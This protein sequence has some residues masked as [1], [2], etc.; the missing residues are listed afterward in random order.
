MAASTPTVKFYSL[1]PDTKPPVR[2]DKSV[3]GTIPT[4][5]YRYCDAVRS[6]SAFG[7]YVFPP[8][9]FS[10]MWDGTETMWRFDEEDDWKNLH[11]VQY[12]GF[13][14]YFN[15]HAPEEIEDCAPPIF[16]TAAEPGIV[17]IW[18]G[19]FAKTRKN[20]SLLV[21]PPANLARSAKY[22]SYEGIIETDRW[23]GPLFTNIRLTKT[24]VAVDITR[25]RPFMQVQPLHRSTYKDEVLNSFEHLDDISLLTKRNWQD[26]INTMV[27][28][29]VGSDREKGVYAKNTRKR[30]KQD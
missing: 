12:P 21:R 9:D 17:Q 11:A 25:D 2:A 6:A 19:L 5:A 10:L 7:W 26:Y 18:S 22:D 28:P 15:S 29:G 16:G 23:F 8:I 13:L 4:S 24:D 14:D 27:A 3:G 30:S 20:W 1:I